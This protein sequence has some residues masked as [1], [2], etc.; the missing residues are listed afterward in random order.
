MRAPSLEKFM[1]V[2][3]VRFSCWQH[4][5]QSEEH[6]L[7]RMWI[8]RVA[9][10][11]AFSAFASGHWRSVALKRNPM[12]ILNS[13]CVMS[14][15]EFGLGNFLLTVA[16]KTVSTYRPDIGLVSSQ[17]LSRTL[18]T[19]VVASV[20]NEF[21]QSEVHASKFRCIDCDGYIERKLLS[22]G[23]TF[24]STIRRKSGRLFIVR[25][26]FCADIPGSRSVWKKCASALRLHSRIVCA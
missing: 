26:S 11:I 14:P 8:I 2:C 19:C 13:T 22:F 18:V 10:E 5:D 9:S 1:D 23:N 20:L 21:R 3:D 16:T 12:H 4:D 17:V 24:T 25:R 6:P 15:M 7:E